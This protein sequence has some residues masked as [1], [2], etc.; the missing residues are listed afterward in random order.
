MQEDWKKKGGI[1]LI[2]KPLEW[3]SFDVVKKIRNV[4]KYKK[5]GHAGTL[6]PLASGLLILCFGNYTKRIE[7]IQSQSKTYVAKIELGKSTPSFDLETAVDAEKAYDHVNLD[8][9][10]EVLQ[11]F[12]GEI[13]QVPPVYSAL[14]VKGKRAYDYARSG[15]EIV[16]KARAVRIYALQIIEFEPPFLSLQI[17]CSKG[18]YIRSL[19]NDLGKSLGTLA[20]LVELRRT[21]IGAYSVESAH[22]PTVF[23][24]EEELYLQRIR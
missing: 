3:T 13:Q 10:N 14:K 16:L 1:L 17:E 23:K 5:I 12:Q 15:E 8:T 11:D 21:D 19:A 4:L 24:T 6:D 2:D 18:T 22:A 7:D 9:I 20:H